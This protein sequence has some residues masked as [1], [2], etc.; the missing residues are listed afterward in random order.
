VHL[1]SKV[2]AIALRLC[3][4]QRFEMKKPVAFIQ[5]RRPQ[6]LIVWGFLNITEHKNNYF[7]QD[8][9]LN[10]EKLNLVMKK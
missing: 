3:V 4:R 9:L 1:L 10:R 5:F 7:V 8:S 2:L 6:N